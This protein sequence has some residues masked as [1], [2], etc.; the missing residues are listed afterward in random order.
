MRLCL[1]VVALLVCARA[2]AL[3]LERIGLHPAA[4]G[5]Q[6]S[7]SAVCVLLQAVATTTISASIAAASFKLLTAAPTRVRVSPLTS[8]KQNFTVDT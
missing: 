4:I 6:Q 3:T 1:V 2:R 5:A 7:R 8:E